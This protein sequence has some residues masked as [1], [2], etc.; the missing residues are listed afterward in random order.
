MKY[1]IGI[2]RLKAIYC[3]RNSTGLSWGVGEKSKMLFRFVFNESHSG[4]V[5]HRLLQRMCRDVFCSRTRR[6]TS[7]WS[8][9]TSN[10]CSKRS[11]LEHSGG[12]KVSGSS[13]RVPFYTACRLILL[14]IRRN[15]MSESWNLA[16]LHGSAAPQL[17]DVLHR[18]HERIVN[19]KLQTLLSLTGR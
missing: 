10:E 5:L 14:S 8:S 6:G 2:C 7:S 11:T 18:P 4:T 17:W 15:K 13:I 9:A 12:I 3:A 19:F 1:I 16:Q